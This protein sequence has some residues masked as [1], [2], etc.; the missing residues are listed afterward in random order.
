[1]LKQQVDR[2]PFPFPQIEIQSR[3]QNDPKDFTWKDF[4]L[5]GYNHHPSIPMSMA[6]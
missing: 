2:T 5:I 4:K 1:V 3:G 6:V